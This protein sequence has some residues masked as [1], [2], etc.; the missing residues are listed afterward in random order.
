[1]AGSA[2][3][4]AAL[5]AATP[6]ADSTRCLACHN[7]ITTPAGEDVSIGRDWRTSMMANAARDPYWQAAVRRETLEH[8]AA[9]AAIQNECSA[10][11][12]PM[13]RYD[14]KQAGAMGEVFAHLPIGAV[15]TPAAGLA[16]DGVSCTL[17]H[18]IARG[19]GPQFN[20]GFTIDESP[21]VFGGAQ[22]PAGNARVMS[23]ATGFTPTASNHLVMPW[24]CA[25][26]HTLYTHALDENGNDAGTL[27][28]QVPYLEWR[29][30]TYHGR[31]MCASCHMPVVADA[32]VPFT[33]VLGTP[34]PGFARHQF[35][36]G[37]FFLA[38]LFARY[39]PELGVV[40]PP[41]ELELSARRTLDHL[42]AEAASLAIENAAVQDGALAAEI[43]VT[44]LAGHKLPTAYPSRRV[45]L[46]LRVV[47]AAGAVV[48]E[49]G[50]FAKDGSIE[51]NDN[52][53][54]SSRF[55][56]HHAVI[57]SPDDVQIYEAVLGDAKGRVTTGLIAA[58]RYLK[59]NRVLP[60]GFDKRN[61]HEDVRVHGEADA[62]DDFHGGSDRVR[63]AI[64][65]GAAAGPFRVEAELL[66][67]PV[68][69]RW[70]HNLRA[71]DAA[72]IA[73]FVTMYEGMASASATQLA[74]VEVALV[75]AGRSED[76]IPHR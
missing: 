20:A 25:S 9:S 26:C 24:V 33:S 22:I 61:A 13:M 58:V 43:V 76:A 54:D 6:F 35:R 42:A 68:G 72:E 71:H 44:N 73:R 41:Q 75:D 34:R 45:W 31:R 55:E 69:Y 66:Y 5:L 38:R 1:M 48:F 37:N 21:A 30:S 28:E 65:V 62:D 17:C 10:C 8:A 56:P 50:R 46:H 40:A 63:V 27:P 51:G 67:Q 53:A 47:D 3:L 57:A 64:D 23:S 70:A 60:E 7:G 19:G 14:A 39:G 29:Q 2:L 12:M 59:D 74:R 4:L 11:H 15:A 32:Q 16:A 36:G 49:S 52:D 18:R